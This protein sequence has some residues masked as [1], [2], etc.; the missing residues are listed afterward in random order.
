MH[1]PGDQPLAG[2]RLPLDQQRGQAP[3]SRLA[4]QD[5]VQ[6]VPDDGHGRALPEQFR[7]RFHGSG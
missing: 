4:L 5:F 3:A 2:A 1:E 7:Q 6:P